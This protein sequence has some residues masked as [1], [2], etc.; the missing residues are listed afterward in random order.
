[1]IRY[2]RILVIAALTGLVAACATAPPP[3]QENACKIFESKRSWYSAT[4]KV[5]KKYGVPISLQ[6]AIVKQESAFRSHAK[7]ERGK[8][9]FIFPGA[10]PS[11]ATGYAQALDTTWETYKADTGRRFSDRNN[12]SDAVDFIGWYADL[13]RQRS[14][15]RPG[16]AYNQYLAYHEGQG[17]YNRG[18]YRSKPGVQSI[19]RQVAHTAQTYE[20]QLNRC[21]K[22]FRRGIPLIPFI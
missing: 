12:F 4:R 22:K 19:A 17:G 3:Q 5:E 14:G 20:S 18:T 6:L 9:L 10:R 1:M 21:E 7:P 11:S 15:I 2:S 16:D 13:S 8:F